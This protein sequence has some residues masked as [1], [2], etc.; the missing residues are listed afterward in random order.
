MAHISFEESIKILNDNLPE[1]KASE[2]VFL[3]ESLNRILAK[4]IVAKYDNP[5]MPTV[6]MDGYAINYYDIDKEIK[7]IGKNPF[8][9]F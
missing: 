1:N 4:A 5:Y 7:I 2:K 9:F 6:S 3:D 8:T